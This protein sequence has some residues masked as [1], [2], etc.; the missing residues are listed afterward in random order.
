MA[1]IRA[2]WGIQLPQ[3]ANEKLIGFVHSLQTSLA[4]T[5]IRWSAPENLHITLQFLK[6][7]GKEDIP[8]LIAQVTQQLQGFSPFFIQLGQVELFPSP[9]MPHVISL[10]VQAST[11]LTNLAGRVGEGMIRAGYDIE[12]RPY[13]PHL[14]LGRLHRKGKVLL[15]PDLTGADLVAIP[16]RDICLWE[17]KP[18][19]QGSCYTL[20]HK[21]AIQ[22]E[23]R[24][25]P[26]G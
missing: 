22:N 15:P 21:L 5:N 9:H 16:V 11:T 25:P 14:T 7:V 1:S 8:S 20:L 18:S 24:C 19:R 2:F 23:C 10:K 12:Q 3:A 4:D 13:R 6:S 26:Q 17:S